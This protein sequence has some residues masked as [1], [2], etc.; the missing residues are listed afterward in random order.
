MDDGK[1]SRHCENC[2]LACGIRQ[3][4]G[5][6]ADKSDN[7]CGVD[8]GAFRLLVLAHGDHGVLAA[9]PD[10]LY[11]DGLGKVPDLLR[12]VDCVIVLGVHDTCVV[13]YDI[14]AAPCVE[15]LN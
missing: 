7:G 2:T 8:N 1:F 11:V 6:G 13:E 3:L 9:E 4:G 12:G 14:N 10:T 5:C 15:V